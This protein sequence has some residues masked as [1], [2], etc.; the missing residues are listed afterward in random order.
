MIR[1]GCVDQQYIG[2]GETFEMSRETEQAPLIILGTWSP[3]L[4][5]DDSI[6]LAEEPGCTKRLA[7]NS[8]PTIHITERFHQ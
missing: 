8:T 1:M 3:L 4:G 7:V 5:D 2:I 6:S